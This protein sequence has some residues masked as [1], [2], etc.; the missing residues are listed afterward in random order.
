MRTPF[1]GSECWHAQP[2]PNALVVL[3]GDHH[4]AT[5]LP[6][7]TRRHDDADL[8]CRIVPRAYDH[9]S[10]RRGTPVVAPAA[11]RR[12]CL[13]A[14]VFGDD[15]RSIT[16]GVEPVRV[17]ARQLRILFRPALIPDTSWPAQFSCSARIEAS[18]LAVSTSSDGRMA[19]AGGMRTARALS[20]PPP[21]ICS[22]C[23]PASSNASASPGR[24][25]QQ[26]P[27]FTHVIGLRQSGAGV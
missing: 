12:S 22:T 4:H 15:L 27:D 10:D 6:R 3:S 9:A 20:R 13:P 14:A 11:R 19:A 7:K 24:L 18:R 16:F 26:L 8:R 2:S 21:M 23:V 1:L 17:D 5:K 25:R